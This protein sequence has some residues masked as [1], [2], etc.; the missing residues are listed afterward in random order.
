MNKKIL[1]VIAVVLIAATASTVA[2]SVNVSNLPKPQQELAFSVSGTN[3][4]LRF[5]D[6]NV[7]T[8]YIP[9]ATAANEQWKLSIN[10]SKMPGSGWT[11][12]FVYKGYWDNGTNHTCLSEE[13]YPIIN[14]IYSADFRIETN[15]TFTRTFGGPT[16]QSYTF[17]I[18]YP[19]G[20]QTTLNFKL[21][22]IS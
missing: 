14:D 10:A 22:K 3:T 11:D 20:G 9:F 4:C 5:L 7:T 16:P 1:L 6:R 8:C 15:S 19:P 12:V 18:I 2:L 17:F 13:L 21:E